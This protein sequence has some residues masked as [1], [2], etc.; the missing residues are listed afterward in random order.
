MIS[1]ENFKEAISHLREASRLLGEGEKLTEIEIM[2]AF[3]RGI[4][5]V[6]ETC[7]ASRDTAR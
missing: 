4:Q 2:A 3:R 7:I 1:L 5:E 6:G